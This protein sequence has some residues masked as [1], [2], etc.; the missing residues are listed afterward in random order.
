MAIHRIIKNLV[1]TYFKLIRDITH[2]ASLEVQLAK[3]SLIKLIMLSFVIG[4]LLTSTWLCVL[5]L[6]FFL[7]ITNHVSWLVSLCLLIFFNVLI[8]IGISLLM[9]Q[10]KT[11]LFFPATRKQLYGSVNHH[12]E[13]S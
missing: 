1:K 8:I 11:H 2:L 7:L 4:S 6:L 12:K 9:L 5:G 10:I 13:A 3:Q